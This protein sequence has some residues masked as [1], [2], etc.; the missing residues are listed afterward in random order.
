[1]ATQSET[2]IK[3]TKMGE[4]EVTTVFS[5]NTME[6]KTVSFDD[7]INAIRSSVDNDS[8]A[9]ITSPVLPYNEEFGIRTVAYKSFSDGR[10][11]VVMFMKR[12][13]CEVTYH[14]Q[15]FEDVGMP[16]ILF[17]VMLKDN[18]VRNAHVM[19]V[20]DDVIKDTTILYHYPFSNA[21]ERNGNICFGGNKIYDYEYTSLSHVFSLPAM[22]LS[23][24]NNDHMYGKN[25]SGLAYR[26]L[27]EKL[28][29]NDFDD[30]ILQ[31][32]GSLFKNWCEK[33]ISGGY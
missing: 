10:E 2:I 22:F 27:L 24:P 13:R 14:T 26:S 25:K 3:I 5:D 28:T 12:H 19:A 4:V 18:K 7:M 8:D 9:S 33:L 21:S 30:E 11:Q 6:V 17:A 29:H 23:M 15:K 32:N 31:E 16:N 1:M 20:K